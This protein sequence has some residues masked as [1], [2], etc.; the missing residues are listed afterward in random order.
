MSKLLKG[1]QDILRDVL[2]IYKL[3]E[4]QIVFDECRNNSGNKELYLIMDKN[5]YNIRI[6]IVPTANE[7][8]VINCGS[9]KVI[10]DL[11]ELPGVIDTLLQTLNTA[12]TT[13]DEKRN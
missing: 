4:Y 12:G 13:C 5:G 9:I 8:L 10:T 11:H 1:I 2:L 7:H 6:Q 3:A